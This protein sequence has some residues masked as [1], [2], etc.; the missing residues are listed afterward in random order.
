MGLYWIRPYAFLSLDKNN[1]NFLSNYENITS[2]I[3]EKITVLNKPPTGEEYLDL[4]DICI[5]TLENSDY[6]YKSLPELTYN[7]FLVKHS[8]VDKKSDNTMGDP[9]VEERNYWLYSPGKNAEK[10]NKY[11]KEGIMAIKY[12][13][14]IG[15]LKEFNDKEEIRK[16]LQVINNDNTMH[17]NEVLALWQ[18]SKEIKEGDVIFAKKGRHNIIGYGI[19]KSDYY[20]DEKID[21]NFK[22]TRKIEWKEKGM[23]DV[24]DPLITKTLTNI[25]EYP[26]LINNIKSL[27]EE[28]IDITE[29]IIEYPEYTM[30][31]FLKDAFIE[32]NEYN[33]I[34]NLIKYKKNVIL[35]GAPG[36]GKTYLSKRLV[37]SMMGIKDKSRVELVQFHQSYSYED[38]IMGYRPSKD[39]FKLKN[40]IFYEFCKKAQEDKNNDYFFIIDEINRGNLSKIFGELF[41]LIEKD[42]RETPIHLL[43]N[44]ELFSIPENLYIIGLMNTADRSLAML[45]YALRRRFAF[46]DL[47]PAFDTENFKRYETELESTTFNEV[48]YLIQELNNEIKHDETLGEGFQIGHSYFSN[49]NKNEVDNK[50]KYI[51]EYEIIPL[52]SEYYFDEEEKLEIWSN[53]LRSVIK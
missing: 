23:W 6:A 38:F 4:C 2:E 17:T 26:E 42:K 9:I 51:I 21:D 34:I 32:E 48:I 45:D 12:N 5:N 40:G 20:Y 11:Y 41:M 22:H 15:N 53:K 39:G 14:N 28:S 3:V 16:K 43:Y 18:F 49:L 30:D 8:G 35:E 24:D 37:Y 44:E 46:I 47:K 29:E 7:A 10:W 50:L 25:T 27:F 19:V 52:L 33:D 36:V 13:D 31:D 1:K